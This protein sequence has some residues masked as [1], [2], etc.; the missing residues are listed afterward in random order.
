MKR[1]LILSLVM[2]TGLAIWMAGG[3]HVRALESP[4]PT[5]EPPATEQKPLQAYVKVEQIAPQ[6]II[7]EVRLRGEAQPNRVATLKSET[8]GKVVALPAER[9]AR[10][11]Q[12]ETLLTLSMDDR[13]AR[14]ALAEANVAQAQAAYNAAKAL[15]KKGF[16]ADLKVK[17]GVAEL[18]AAQAELAA[19]KLDI[20]RS[21][22]QAPFAGVIRERFIEL[23]EYLAPGD[24]ML[25]LLDDTTVKVVADLPQQKKG[26]LKLGMRGEA[27]WA[28]GH[29]MAGVIHYISPRADPK[30]RTFRVEM[31]IQNPHSDLPMGASVEMRIPLSKVA[32]HHLS[33][34]LLNLDSHGAVGVKRIDAANRVIWSPVKVI[35]AGLDGIWVTGLPDQARIITLGG[36]FVEVGEQVITDHDG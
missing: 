29:K 16:Q 10:V 22:L 31:A 14:K 20:R 1:S 19:I 4:P 30:T 32:A 27:Q 2:A 7:Q 36:G 15:Y 13:Q 9:G 3:E 8:T 34:A 21:R 18:R 12:G 33:P 28:D 17:Q 6:M 5:P 35:K 11:A 24:A 26:S 23:G 25:E